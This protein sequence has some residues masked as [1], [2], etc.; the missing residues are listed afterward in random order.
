MY[1]LVQLVNKYRSFILNIVDRFPESFQKKL[2][3]FYRF[4]VSTAQKNLLKNLAS[5]GFQFNGA[6]YILPDSIAKTN[7]KGINLVGF[8]SGQFGL[9]QH[10]RN[11]G[12]AFESGKIDK[13]YFSI[14]QYSALVS[15]KSQEDKEISQS[16]KYNT[17]IFVCNGDSLCSIVLDNKNIFRNRYNINYGAWEL[18]NYPAEWLPSLNIFD[19]YWAMSS[20]LQKSVSS[21]AIIPVIHM[22]YPID[23]EVPHHIVRKDFN[24][25]E[26]LFLFIFTF[27]ISSLASRKNPQAVIKAFLKAFGNK[28]EVGLVIK[29]SSNKTLKTHSKEIKEIMSLAKNDKRVFLINEV[30]SRE[31]ILGLINSCDVYVSLHRAEGLGIGMAEA[32]KMGK[33]VI[34]TNYSGNTDFTLHDNSCL[35]D[36]K[37]IDVKPLEYI[38]EKGNV[39]AD[40]EIDHAVYYMRK[41]YDDRS[42][43]KK[44]SSKGREY[45]DT[46]Y[47]AKVIM[48]KYHKRLKLLG[49]L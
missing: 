42:Y 36:Y 32:M 31:Y 37:L 12:M 5:K 23:F 17:N 2:R 25:P 16:L 11:V 20:F 8:V 4:Y 45:I 18:S 33:V 21:S 44:L 35:V 15:A 9:G 19:E 38:Y 34:A 49:L 13:I 7:A 26:H 3:Q 27:D 10:L 28:E 41:L 39:W 46:H 29:V 24:L 47:N 43:Y 14:D 22:P 40:P 6:T 30:L 48:E 1:I